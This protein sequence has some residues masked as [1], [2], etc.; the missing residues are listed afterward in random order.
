MITWNKD[1]IQEHES[2]WGIFEKFKFANRIT[3]R[4]FFRFLTGN[5]KA[6]YTPIS[7]EYK[8]I[9]N[10]ISIA[11]D[12]LRIIFEIEIDNYNEKYK[13]LFKSSTFSNIIIFN[14]KL[15]ICQKCISDGYHSIFHQLNFVS[16]CPF[17]PEEQLTDKCSNCK[18]DFRE[19]DLGCRELGFC[20]EN[21]NY[22]LLKKSFY[23]A[24][25]EWKEPKLIKDDFINTILNTTYQNYLKVNYVSTKQYSILVNNNI[26][27]KTIFTKFSQVLSQNT[28]LSVF[29]EKKKSF[30]AAY[31]LNQESTLRIGYVQRQLNIAVEKNSLYPY[32]LTQLRELK[33]SN[34]VNYINT[35]LDFELF[36]R[37]KSIL[38][39]VDRYIQ[40]K[41]NLKFNLKSYLENNS[42]KNP[43]IDA[44]KEWKI[45]CYNIFHNPDK[46]FN[47]LGAHRTIFHFWQSF[48]FNHTQI[49][50]FLNDKNSKIFDRVMR[51]FKNGNYS[52]SLIANVFSKLLFNFLYIKFQK[53]LCY[54]LNINNPKHQWHQMPPFIQIVQGQGEIINRVT[55]INFFD[56]FNL[57]LSI[58]G[59]NDIKWKS[60]IFH[61]S[62]TISKL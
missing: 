38:K 20:C 26:I 46:L 50:P 19:Y 62:R 3:G 22:N 55:F 2:L 28:P 24:I 40:R 48:S 6:S 1:W 18:E 52:F 11:K 61:D 41:I 51:K 37:S 25:K 45:S 47:R 36:N 54:S 13:D 7:V 30:S 10:L 8:S 60:D 53:C 56:L 23:L 21:C 9:D 4:E 29:V 15:C 27:Y 58:S 16:Y 14:P 44:Y 34:Y 17:H 5:K 49:Y 42:K 43:Y 31:K 59:D 35:I 32:Q 57:D 12:R 39:S 33:H